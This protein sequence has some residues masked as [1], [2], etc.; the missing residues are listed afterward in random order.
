LSKGAFPNSRMASIPLE[1]GI[2]E[3]LARAEALEAEGRPD[4]DSPA[5]AKE[6]AK[7]AL[8]AGRVHYT[9]MSGDEELREAIALKYRR[10]NGLE[11]DPRT[12]IVVTGGAIEALMMT[13]LTILEPGDEVLIPSPFFPAYADQVALANGRL[14]DV[15]CRL[16]NEFR[17]RVEDLEAALTP[18]TRV[19]LL[20]TPNN[21]S[22]AVLTRRDLEQVG[23]LARERN[24]WVVSDEC[25]EK[26]LYEGEHVSIASLPGMAERTVTIGAASKTWSM[27]GW[28]I[29]WALMPPEMKRYA[30][31]C[32]QNL[33]TCGNAFAQAGV[34]EAFRSAEENVR[35]MIAEYRRRRDLVM[36]YLNRMEGIEAVQPHGAFYVFPRV[37]ALGLEPM[38]FC[39]YLLEEAGVS[40]VPGDVF[41]ARGFIRMAYC[42][43]YDYLEEGLE[44]MERAVAK[45][46]RRVS[47]PARSAA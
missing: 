9:D 7:R 38:E 2:R 16:E 23:A 45:L 39:S 33:S 5:C 17:L 14:V 21:P 4:F 32:H 40:T 6:A 26:F 29:G 10:E 13:F 1:G 15:P 11:A 30:T 34:T 22:G 18:R 19:I 31:K 35:K 44:R 47:P 36:S 25:Y 12:Q 20:N 3:I 41:H 28:R 8:D 27:T 43:S 46:R 42:R 24:V 37:E